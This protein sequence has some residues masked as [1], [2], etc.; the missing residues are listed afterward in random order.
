MHVQPRGAVRIHTQP[1]F[2]V[3]QPLVGQS[4]HDVGDECSVLEHT[5]VLRKQALHLAAPQQVGGHALLRCWAQVLQPLLQ[6][7]RSGRRHPDVMTRDGLPRC[8]C[9]HADPLWRLR[10]PALGDLSLQDGNPSRGRHQSHVD[11]ALDL[12]IPEHDVC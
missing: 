6:P 3:R 12:L 9:T 4:G 11:K 1:L 7:R 10:V 5:P 2:R 8:Q